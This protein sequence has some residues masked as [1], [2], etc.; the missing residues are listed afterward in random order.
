MTR[1]IRL[2]H[3][4]G[5]IDWWGGAS[6]E[7]RNETERAWKVTA[8]EVKARGYNLDIKNPQHSR[9][10]PRRP[11]GASGEADCRGGRNGGTAR[12]VED[13][14]R[15]G[16][17]PMNDGTPARPLRSDSPTHRRPFLVCA[18]SFS[19]SPSVA[20]SVKQHPHDKPASELLKQI[21]KKK[22][23]MVK[24]GTIKLRK[25]NARER[26]EPLDLSVPTGWELTELG[27]IA[28]KITDGAHKTPTLR[29]RG[30]SVRECQGFQWGYS[31]SLEYAVH[32]TK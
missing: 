17:N 16:A 26:E 15:R 9:R 31:R 28:E 20:S 6:R 3:L 18:V 2:E 10:R 8:E 25:V 5:C 19:I 32:S 22:A 29:Q 12:S 1:P 4:Q 13:D 24:T 27:V 30:R 11:G 23:R 14:P 7:G 21:A